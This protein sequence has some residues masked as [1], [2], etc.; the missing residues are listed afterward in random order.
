MK[1]NQVTMAKTNFFSSVDQFNKNGAFDL[2]GL[3]R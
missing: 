2:S 1:R 3:V